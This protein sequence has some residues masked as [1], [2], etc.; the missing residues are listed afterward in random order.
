[1]SYR[2]VKLNKDLKCEY[3]IDTLGVVVNET[4]GYVLKG[5]SIN[6]NNRY[7]KIHLDKFYPLH[8]LV[9]EHFNPNPDNLPQVNHKDGNRYNNTASNLEWC[10]A[11]DNVKHA[12]SS[13]LKTNKGEINPVSKLT[14]RDVKLIWS[15]R[16]TKLT[17]R[18]IRDR[19]GLKVSV[20]S[21]KSVRQGKNWSWLTDTLS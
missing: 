9:A 3:S 5:T 19:L 13:G 4:K 11:K 6:K 15:L 16:N 17:A 7:V 10:S 14:E 8:R 1:M 2:K 12:Y 20:A 18:Q 21:V